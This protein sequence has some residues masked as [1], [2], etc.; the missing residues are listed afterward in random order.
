MVRVS[1]PFLFLGE[2]PAIDFV[3]TQIVL[4]GEPVDL[5][6]DD[7][8]LVRWMTESGLATHAQ[9]RGKRSS[10]LPEAKA[11]RGELRRIFER[12]ARG[13]SLRSADLDA[14][15]G[16]LERG[17]GHLRLALRGERPELGMSFLRHPSPAF[18]VARAA[19]EFLSTADLALVRQCEGAGC[20]LLFHD[21]TKSHTRR[22]CTMS[23]CGNRAKAATHYKRLTKSQKRR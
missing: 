2:H 8:D 23:G 16:V 12:L 1:I 19:A 13:E 17:E 18:L 20:I 11:L 21:T 7:A 22:W 9:L 4:H 14:L 15:N 10:R 6:G 5:L 3:N